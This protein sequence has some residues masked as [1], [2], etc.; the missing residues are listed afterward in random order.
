MYSTYLGGSSFDAATAIALSDCDQVYVTGFTASTDF[1][2]KGAIQK[3]LN[4]VENAFVTKFYATGTALAFSSYLGGSGQDVANGIAVDPEENAYLAG[5]TSSTD[6]PTKN[7]IQ[8][9]NH[10]NTC[11]NA[12]V[13]KI[14]AK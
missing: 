2:L 4:G 10:C 6:F 14:S 3:K 11:T 8:N 5:V 7:A 1:P 12:F 13:T 9:Q